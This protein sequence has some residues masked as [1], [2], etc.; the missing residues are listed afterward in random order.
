MQ[1][2]WRIIL[3]QLQGG[4]VLLN[5]ISA[6]FSKFIKSK[7]FILGTIIVLSVPVFII[8]KDLFFVPQTADYINYIDWLMSGLS[9]NGIILPIISGFIIT[10]LIQREYQDKT[11]VNVLTSPVSR[12]CFILSKVLVWFVWYAV[13]LLAVVAIYILGFYLIFTET[14]DS[15]GAKTFIEYFSKFGFLS[16]ISFLPLLW[17]IVKQRMI[18][19]PSIML[20]LLLAAI[21]MAGFHTS[22]EM[23]LLASIVPWTAVTILSFG[24]PMPYQII[25]IISILGSGVLGLFFSCYSFNKQ[26]Q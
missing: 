3:N 25:C 8:I 26:D 21:Q 9:L 1:I 5:I 18:F 17:V 16:Y 14:F 7:L 12:N 24:V 10:V 15:D 20:A 13:T 23:L 11:I 2:T 22:A 4:A 19:Y 6:E